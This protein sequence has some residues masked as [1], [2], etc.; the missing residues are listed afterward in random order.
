MLLL[1]D[2]YFFSGKWKPG[3]DSGAL[4]PRWNIRWAGRDEFQD[5][6]VSTRM[7]MDHFPFR[8]NKA[9][10][11]LAWRWQQSQL[12]NDKCIVSEPQFLTRL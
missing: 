6:I 5:I 3:G 9:L 2:N 8:I 7:L 4:P 11:D 10:K 12:S 1:P